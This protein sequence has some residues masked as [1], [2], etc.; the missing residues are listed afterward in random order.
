[1]NSSSKVAET[2]HYHDP[3]GTEVYR[4]HVAPVNPIF[5]ET[6]QLGCCCCCC[7]CPS[8]CAYK[9]GVAAAAV[10]LPVISAASCLGVKGLACS[11]GYVNAHSW[12]VNQGYHLVPLGAHVFV[13]WN[14]SSH[15][16]LVSLMSVRLI[17]DAHTNFLRIIVWLISDA[18]TD[19][20]RIIRP[21]TSIPCLESD[22]V[23]VLYH[24]LYA[25]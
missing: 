23:F 3:G 2:S 15:S 8:T 17:S 20:L 11:K 16:T 10:F 19:F 1:V 13:P 18:H 14:T 6:G 4:P 12:L 21:G 24:P 22:F 25:F 5:V 7:C 9:L